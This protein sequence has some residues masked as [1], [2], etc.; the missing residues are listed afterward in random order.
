MLN[1]AVSDGVFWVAKYHTLCVAR[2][3]HACSRGSAKATDT[4]RHT[5]A[6]RH[7]A[8][9][10][11]AVAQLSR[12]Q[13]SAAPQTR[14]TTTTT[15]T[16]NILQT[17]PTTF[18]CAQRVMCASAHDP[19]PSHLT[20][21][22]HQSALRPK[23]HTTEMYEKREMRVYVCGL[24]H[25][26]TTVRYAGASCHTEQQTGRPESRQWPHEIRE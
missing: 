14:T 6:V 9:L 12:S 17:T 26:Y 15:T 21:A 23:V 22:C 19:H 2:R 4:T 7:G 13:T 3:A 18:D 5:D 16:M 24:H 1:R 10:A 11:T 20:T 25:T 8:L